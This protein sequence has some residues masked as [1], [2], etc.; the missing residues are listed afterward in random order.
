MVA[1]PDLMSAMWSGS[2]LAAWLLGDTPKMAERFDGGSSNEWK[3]R[4]TGLLN[5]IWHN[6]RSVFAHLP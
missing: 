3:I 2:L 1:A 6:V 4:A 5:D